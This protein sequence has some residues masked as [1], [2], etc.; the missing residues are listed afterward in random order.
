MNTLQKSFTELQQNLAQLYD[1]QEAKAI[2][3]ILLTDHFQLNWHNQEHNQLFETLFLTDFEQISKRLLAEEP[4]QYVV[5]VAWFY[6]LKFKVNSSTL[7]P[8]P[9]TE[10]LVEWVLNEFS[11]Q[12]KKINILDIGTG[13]GC[14]PIVMK[15]K[16]PHWQVG[17]LDVSESALLTASRNAWRHETEINFRVADIL[18]ENEWDNIIN[19]FKEIDIIVSNPPYIGIDEKNKI[20]NN[21]L[22][23][24]PHLALFVPNNDILLFY[25][26]IALFLLKVRRKLPLTEGGKKWLFFECHADYAQN[27]CDLL[28][29]FGFQDITLK[30]DLSGK[31]RLVKGSI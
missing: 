6:G 21:V 16:R 29:N 20:A 14:I 31:N 12:Q 9:E 1:P 26:K 30:R 28:E 23:Y 18:A 10:E 13:S 2:I 22:N 17:A 4:I 5:G 7:I 27:V 11:I 25:R 15:R 3:R 8:R 24:E 19:D